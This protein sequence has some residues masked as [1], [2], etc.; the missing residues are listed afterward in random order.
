MKPCIVVLSNGEDDELELGPFNQG[1][2]MDEE[3]IIDI[4]TDKVIAVN[5]SPSM[6]WVDWG[7]A[8][9]H[10]NTEYQ[11]YSKVFIHARMPEVDDN[12]IKRA[13]EGFFS[14]PPTG[15]DSWLHKPASAMKRALESFLGC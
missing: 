9:N 15:H 14:A 6:D 1:V 3:E 11:S 7:V 10:D 8:F 12:A 13:L 4:A 5:R 2:V